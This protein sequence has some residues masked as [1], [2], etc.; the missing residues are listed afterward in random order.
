MV[1]TLSCNI[2]LLVFCLFFF[3]Y[4]HKLALSDCLS[5]HLF[6]PVTS[7][8]FFF[9]F[10]I[11]SLLNLH[12]SIKTFYLVY[13][14][15]FLTIV[16]PQIS[17]SLPLQCNTSNILSFVFHYYPLYFSCCLVYVSSVV[18]LPFP[19]WC[20]LTSANLLCITKPLRTAVSCNSSK[21][22]FQICGWY[23]NIFFY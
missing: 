23:F 8:L 14:N 2:Y 7:S 16:I 6:F 1:V 22:T 15:L 9:F 5:F 12:C 11:F 20:A 13:Q 10:F 17:F 19:A 18:P 3:L 21:N 4:F